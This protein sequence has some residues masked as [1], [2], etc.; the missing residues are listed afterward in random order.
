MVVV[1]SVRVVGRANVVHL[2]GRTTLHAARLGLFAGE[3]DPE[4]VVGVG[5]EA[6]AAHVLLVASRVDNN[7]VLWRAYNSSAT[8]PIFPD[9]VL[10]HTETAGVQWPHVEN[11]NAL[12]LSEN[13]QTLKTGGL[14]DIRGNGTGLRTRGKKV[15]ITLDLCRCSCQRMT[16][17]R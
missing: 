13:F 1:V 6:G 8:G 10:L 4:N 12:H 11:V 2:V 17:L 3:G 14:L 15:G 5:R 9:S 7:G 16:L